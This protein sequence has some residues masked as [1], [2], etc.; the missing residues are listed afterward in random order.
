MNNIITTKEL[1][2]YIQSLYNRLLPVFQADGVYK[3]LDVYFDVG[4]PKGIDGSFCY[5]DNQGYHFG[6]SDRGR[7]RANI[8]TNSLKELAFVVLEEE[9]FW[10]AHDYE[11]QHRIE[12]QD[13]RRLLF[14]KIIQYWNVIGEEY[15]DLARKDIK[16]IL[17][18]AP[19]ID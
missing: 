7:Q 5:S 11:K 17:D 19:F 15:A 16:K 13:S 1:E 3:A 9:I 8:T 6:V 4:T 12:G 18:K 10:V 2:K 14:Q